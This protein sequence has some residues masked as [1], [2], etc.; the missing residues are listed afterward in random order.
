MRFQA[1]SL[2]RTTPEKLFAFHELPDALTRL[3]PPWEK[4][5]VI[6]RS[7]DLRVGSRTIV[8]A[9][10][11]PGIFMRWESRHTAY[12]PPRL[13]EDQQV[14]GPFRSWRHRHIVEPHAEG[15][16]LVDDIEYTLPLGFL[17]RLF[18]GAAIER[19]LRRVFAFRHRVT[20][21]YCENASL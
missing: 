13:F 11:A 3:M 4:S 6:E 18:A 2:I 9:R 5:R 10:I 20:R 14:R 1:R 15:A 16:L 21:E 7:P 12:D 19:R 17:G 8:E